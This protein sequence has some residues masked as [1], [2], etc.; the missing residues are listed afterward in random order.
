MFLAVVLSSC[1]TTKAPKPGGVQTVTYDS[2]AIPGPHPREVYHTVAPGETLWRIAQMYNVD[3]EKIKKA[4]RVNNVQDIDIGSKLYI[5]GASPRK[6]VVTLYPNTKWKYIIVHHSATDMGSSQ[7]FHY[8]HKK[9]GWEAIGYHFVIDNGSAGKDKGQIETSPRWIKQQNGAHCRAGGMNENG[10]GICLVG[11]FSNDKVSP[12]QMDS[13]VRL[14]KELKRYYKIPSSNIMGHGQVPG[15]A[16]EC[17]GK[18]FPWSEFWAKVG[19]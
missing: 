1:A 5:P 3:M 14:V 11:N 6:N 13:L 9:K 8:A 7:Q 4:N 19:R 15:A 18:K 17:P 16:T 12:Q 10:I 2:P